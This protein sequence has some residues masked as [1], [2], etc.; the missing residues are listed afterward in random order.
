MLMVI[1]GAGASFDSA[2]SHPIVPDRASY[3]AAYSEFRPPLANDLFDRREIFRAALT[4]YPYLAHVTT[5]LRNRADGKSVEEVLQ[6]LSEIR[7]LNSIIPHELLAVRYYL[8]DVIGL[9]SSKWLEEVDGITNQKQLVQD[10]TSAIGFSRDQGW[11]ERVLFVT[12]NYDSLIE[13][14]LAQFGFQVTN[15]DSYFRQSPHFALY[16]LHGSYNWARF[17]DTL[18]IS[19]MSLKS[20]ASRKDIMEIVATRPDSV[21][22]SFVILDDFDKDYIKGED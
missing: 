12:F 15:I 1:M 19:M 10:I 8:R 22:S 20:R 21:H 5:K 6:S 2:A 11:P 13:D 4:R 16:K 9:C 14:A 18:R 17:F 3:G 7:D